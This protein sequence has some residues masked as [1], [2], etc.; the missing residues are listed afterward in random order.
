LCDSFAAAFD[1][2]EGVERAATNDDLIPEAPIP[3]PVPGA[4]Q[5]ASGKKV[6]GHSPNVREVPVGSYDGFTFYEPAPRPRAPRP[7]RGKRPL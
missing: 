7:Q 5:F 4:L 6:P 1:I 2:A 3:N